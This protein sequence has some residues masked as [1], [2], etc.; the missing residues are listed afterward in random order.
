M[1]RSLSEKLLAALLIV[2]FG[3]VLY[4]LSPILSNKVFPAVDS[5]YTKIQLLEV[6]LILTAMLLG[7]L[8]VIGFLAFCYSKLKNEHYES[9]KI[10]RILA[11]DLQKRDLEIR[12]LKL[13]LEAENN[14]EKDLDK[15]Q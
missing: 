15:K 2:L 9:E 3:S 4:L 5:Q 12:Q 7:I 1:L 11:T 14:K 13:K 10:N 6:I 8:I